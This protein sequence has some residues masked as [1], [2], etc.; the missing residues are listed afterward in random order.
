VIYDT[1]HIYVT[2]SRNQ[3]CRVVRLSIDK[4]SWW[5][6]IWSYTRTKYG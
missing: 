3:S 4:I 1:H 6:R 5:A 2:E